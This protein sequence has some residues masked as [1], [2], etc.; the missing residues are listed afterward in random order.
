[1]QRIKT[2]R[3]LVVASILGLVTMTAIAVARPGHPKKTDPAAKPGDADRAQITVTE[4]KGRLGVSVL[5][6]SPELRAHLGAP[7]DRGVLVDA[8]RA[9]GPA[10]RAGVRVGDVIVEV[11]GD[12]AR[13][14]TEILRAMLDRKKGDAVKIAVVRDRSRTE[15]TATL[16]DDPGVQR[17]IRSGSGPGGLDPSFGRRFRDMPDADQ[18]DPAD[19]QRQ[20]DDARRR[21]DELERR[22][23]T[24]EPQ[25]QPQSP[26]PQ[27]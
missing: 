26:Q 16:E 20:L 4:G 19:L 25:P 7:G 8:V 24:L 12:A 10:A 6:I 18:L 23:R 13:S 11:D 9:D 5:Q 15:L 3:L 14:A 22:F 1:M 17:V 21:I 27:H 2:R